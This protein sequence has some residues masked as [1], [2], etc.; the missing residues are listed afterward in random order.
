[1]KS[2]ERA[3]IL[4]AAGRDFHNFLVCFKRDLRTEVVAFTAA[5]IPGI[6]GRLFPP[7]L[8]GRRYPDGIPIYPESRLEELIRSKG[9]ARAYF[10]YSDVSH[11]YVMNLASRVLAAGACFSLI[12]PSS[13]ML[14]SSKPVISVVAV[15]TGSGKSQT[16][17]RVSTILRELGIKPVVIRHPMSYGNLEKTAVQRFAKIQDLSR[18]DLTVEEVE[19]FE[20]HIREGNVVYAGVDYTRILRRAEK[21]GDVIIWDGGN[22]DTSFIRSVLTITVA[23]P[24]RAGDEINF[25]PGEVNLILAD[26]V[27]IN[28]CDTAKESQIEQLKENIRTRNRK[29]DILLADSPPRVDRPELIRGKRVLCIED[30]PSHTHGNRRVGAAYFAAKRYGAR[31]IVDPRP[32]ARGELKTVF[33]NYP[34]L[35]PVLPALGYHPKQLTEMEDTIRRTPCDT[36]LVGT[37]AD[38]TRLIKIRQPTVRVSYSLV[39]RCKGGLRKT[40]KRVLSNR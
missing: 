21:E 38:I 31:K 6:D 1:M 5:Q 18:W 23:D 12:S 27:V 3:I 19:E 39:E 9:I 4:G 17:R 40:I 24:H 15:R 35:G 22:N 26:V 13:A 10:S 37:P 34:H 32:F 11:T 36:V 33:K 20:Q 2:I 7:V 30:G 8:A 28:K 29:C 14:E 25:F 16:T